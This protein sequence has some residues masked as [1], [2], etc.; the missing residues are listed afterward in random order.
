MQKTLL[1]I[2]DGLGDRPIKDFGGKTPLESAKTPNMDLLAKRGICGVMNAM[3][4]DLYPT[5]EEAHLAILGYD[6]KKD[7]PGRGVLE[8]LGIGVKLKK[9]ELAF[10]VDFSTVDKDL[11]LI[12]ARAGVI[13]SVK[14]LC[15]AVDNIEIDNIRFKIY[16]SLQHRAVLVVSGDIVKKYIKEMDSRLRGN[17]NGWISDTDPHKAGPHKLG[18]RVLRPKATGSSREGKTI[19]RAL[20]RYQLLSHEILN[21]NKINKKRFKKGLLA[22]NFITTRGCGH[23]KDI[24]DFKEKFGAK[25]ACIAG[26]PLYKGISIYLGMKMLSV[27][28]ATGKLDTNVG[29]KVKAS[30]KALKKYDFVFLHIKGTDMAGEDYG[31][32]KMKRDFIEKIDKELGGFLNI[33]NATIAI[34]GDHATPCELKDHSSDVVPVL[35]SPSLRHSERSEAKSRKPLK[36][37][38]DKGKGFLRS[39]FQEV[40][41]NDNQCHKD[42][43]NKFGESYCKEG[44]LGHIYGKDFMKTLLG[45]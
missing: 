16:P 17:D 33:K 35:I 27:R 28:G 40:G 21:E 42:K 5:S 30:L 8:A 32:G 29:A 11:N 6:F 9:D 41:R 25:S 22:A 15:K 12:D 45:E 43:V 34:T 20:E 23:L 7:H 3:P 10:R 37:D 39:S 19:A 24:D 38:E 4:K 14:D 31:D 2:L 36:N 26:A 44:G 13:D 1:V 18:V